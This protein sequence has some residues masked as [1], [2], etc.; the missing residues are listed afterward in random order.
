MAEE[1]EQLSPLEEA[2]LASLQAVDDQIALEHKRQPSEPE[3]RGVDEGEIYR[4]RVEFIASFLIGAAEADQVGLNSLV[5]FTQAFA[6]ALAMTVDD[7]AS[8]GLKDISTSY[9]LLAAK[10][11]EKDAGKLMRLLRAP[12]ESSELS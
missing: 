3:L 1:K 6:K 8:E 10:S 12:D 2:I 5:V 4:K 7:R 9:A 11:V